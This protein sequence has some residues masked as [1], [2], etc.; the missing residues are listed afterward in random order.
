MV[1]NG[2]V[3]RGWDML[4]SLLQPV[5]RPKGPKVLRGIFPPP[6]RTRGRQAVENP[7]Y[8]VRKTRASQ[9]IVS[10]IRDMIAGG[11][12]KAGDR[13]PSER[14]LAEVLDVGRS[15]V[16]ESIRV[17]E[18]LGLVEVRPGGG[19]FLTTSD[20]P[21]TYPILPADVFAEWTLRLNLFEL[22]AMLEPELAGLAARRV[23]PACLN[24]MRAVLDR[25]GAKVESGETGM[26]EDELFHALVA[27][28]AGNPALT[29]LMASV[30]HRLRETR[31]SSVQGNGRPLRSLEQ[32]KS[33]LAAIEA[34]NPA[35]AA[36]RMR[37]HIRSIER[38]SFASGTR[39][40]ESLNAD[41]QGGNE[42]P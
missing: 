33:V 32:N 14:E 7:F 30:A 22:R 2:A 11:R 36:R 10:Q 5:D 28:A 34:R 20:H 8:P 19:T 16:R 26:D 31:D 9:E 1:I 4:T 17:L 39:S 37:A 18:S 40:G 23:T 12:L 29:Q 21:N 6:E 41:Q 38:L 24:K 3:T 42:T 13:L 27:E 35:M 25:Q 15:T